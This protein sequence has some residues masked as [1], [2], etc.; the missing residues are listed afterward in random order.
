M[1]EQEKPDL[2]LEKFNAF[3]EDRNVGNLHL[4]ASVST[5]TAAADYFFYGREIPRGYFDL[6]D[7][8]WRAFFIKDLQAYAI[9]TIKGT[10]EVN[11]FYLLRIEVPGTKNTIDL[12]EMQN[13]QLVHKQQLATYWCRD[14][15]CIQQ[16]SWI[17]D[18]NGDTQLDIIKKINL[19]EY[20][21]KETAHTEEYH[22][23]LLQMED[24]SFHR[25][26]QLKVQIEDYQ[27]EK[28]LEK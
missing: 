15:Y 13:G 23:V 25:S 11:D 5:P 14:H 2:K 27:I 1:I 20:H 18:L 19:V 21:N 12:F 16:D 3:F 28:L 6:I 10:A 22:T 9:G 7:P 8:R 4:Y 26:D 17:L 24:G